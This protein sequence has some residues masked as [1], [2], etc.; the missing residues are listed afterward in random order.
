MWN[1]PSFYFNPN[2]WYTDDKGKDWWGSNF[3]RNDLS[4]QPGMER[5]VYQQFLSDRGFGGGL[6]RRDMFAKSQFGNIEDSF[7]Q[8]LLHN[9]S[10]NRIDFYRQASKGLDNAYASLSPQQRGEFNPQ[11]TRVIRY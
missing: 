6:S 1:S 4:T 8:A 3:V 5:G 2:D 7:K 9:P 10:L 11:Q